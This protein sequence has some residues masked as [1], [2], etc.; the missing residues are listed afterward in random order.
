MILT[1][2]TCRE[3][4]ERL[5]AAFRLK[6]RPLA[7]YG[8]D[9]IPVGA[10]HLSRVDRC[11]AT[12]LYQMATGKDVST[13][14][15]SADEPEG[16][17]LG[18][19]T[20]MGFIQRPEYIKYFVSSGRKDVL[21]GAAEFLKSSPEVV[22]RCIDAVGKITPPGKHLIV[23]ACEEVLQG[24]RNIR[25]ICCFGSAEQVRNLAA[26][27]HFDRDEP[28]SPVIVPWGASCATF[29]SYPA[30]MTEN[31]PK[32]TA[33]MGPQD[34]TQ[35][36]NLPPDTMAIGIPIGVAER[37]VENLEYSFVMKRPQV[38]FPRHTKKS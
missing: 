21:G 35:N 22:E 2:L 34:P 17:C 23:Q 9:I 7:V 30:G 15:V 19:L 32:N 28:F 1:E 38:A 29:I 36:R 37:M 16:C 4:G 12:A 5:R 24:N 25:S 6:T 3:I 27:V 11:L 14:Y 31:A 20:H 13:I 33:F 26:L 18:G 8:S 10:V